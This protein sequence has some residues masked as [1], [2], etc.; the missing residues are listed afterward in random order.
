[1]AFLKRL[2]DLRLRLL[3]PGQNVGREKRPL[4]VISLGVSGL[5]MPTVRCEI[6]ANVIFKGD[7]A[8]LAHW[9]GVYPLLGKILSQSKS[10]FFN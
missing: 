1:M 4:P 3:D 7:F 5:V 8:V 2:P 6:I 10:L 9:G